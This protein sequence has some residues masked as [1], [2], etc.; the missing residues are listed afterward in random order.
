MNKTMR[1]VI[2]ILAG[3][4]VGMIIGIPGGLLLKNYS[5]IAPV[6]VEGKS[7]APG[8]QDEQMMWMKRVTQNTSLERFDIV[9]F[10]CDET[11]TNAIKRIIGLPGETVSIDDAGHIF[12]DGEILEENY[13]SE[14][15]DKAHL[16]KMADGNEITLKEDE[17]FVL[18]DNRNNS[19][20]SRAI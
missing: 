18:G 4:L 20:D 9:L 13:G 2:L 15:I 16:H 5:P 1:Y 11:N 10:K 7:M 17:Y 8:L 6:V 12:I 3:I 19:F 14:P